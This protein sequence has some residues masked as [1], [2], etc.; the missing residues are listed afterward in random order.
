MNFNL[1]SHDNEL[2]RMQDSKTESSFRWFEKTE[3]FSRE[4]WPKGMIILTQP[5]IDQFTIV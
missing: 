5:C 1:T 2:H 3:E 4:G